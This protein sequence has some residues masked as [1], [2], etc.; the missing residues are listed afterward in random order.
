MKTI[1]IVDLKR[2]YRTIR[3]SIDEGIRTV[4]ASQHFILGVQTERFEK[5]FADFCGKR[6]AVALRSGTDALY[7]ALAAMGIKPRDEVIVPALTF[8]A[9]A[10]VVTL[11]GGRVVFC[12][13]DRESGLAQ[14]KDIQKVMTKKSKFVIPVHLYGQ[15]APMDEI[16]RLARSRK[17]QV[18]E[19]AAQ[20]HGAIYK[21]M[22]APIG[23]VAAY[24]F[25]PAKNLGA[26]GDAGA[27]VTDDRTLYENTLLF[28]NHGQP[29]GEKY[30]HV[31]I[32]SNLRMDEIQAAVLSVKLRYLHGWTSRRRQLAK[33]YDRE[34]SKVEGISLLTTLPFSKPAYHLYCI[35]AKARDD[36]QAYLAQKGIE[37]RIHYPLPLHLQPA[38]R[39]LGYRRGDFPNAQRLAAEILCL[40]MFPELTIGE[41]ATVC[42]T[43][44]KFY[45]LQG[46]PHVRQHPVYQH[47][48]S[49]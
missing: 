24:S 36:L 9:T 16:F 46:K 35:R 27:L 42:R 3:P 21:K 12:D 30:R 33:Y 13:V 34:L 47:A 7:A 41:V 45:Q 28:R 32:G 14:A 25:Y 22:M 38:Y 43:I 23:R 4:V 1:P 6:Y 40:P 2:Q 11:L 44:A 15:I 26:Y 5:A 10:E 39:H 20:A 31:R 37:T 8:I 29:K 17:V 19:D 18:I 49:P 48:S